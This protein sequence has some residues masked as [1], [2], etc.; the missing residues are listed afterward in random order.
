MT[1]CVWFGA[2]DGRM[3]SGGAALERAL[4]KAKFETRFRP[5]KVDEVVCRN[6]DCD[7][8]CPHRTSATPVRV[9]RQAGVDV[10]LAVSSL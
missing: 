2:K 9:M 8:N 3:D 10:D 6:R 4:K 5:M 7:E 1:H